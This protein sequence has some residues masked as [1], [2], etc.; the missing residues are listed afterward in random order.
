MVLFLNLFH[1][2]YLYHHHQQNILYLLLSVARLIIFYIHF[3]V[4]GS[5]QIL[6]FFKGTLIILAPMCFHFDETVS[7]F[8]LL[9]V[10][11]ESFYSSLNF[12]ETNKLIYIGIILSTFSSNYL[13][14]SFKI[15]SQI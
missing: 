9:L 6:F 3:A 8:K 7:I 14:L 2:Q 12:I 10:E 11:N 15:S 5:N 1:I 4:L 13:F